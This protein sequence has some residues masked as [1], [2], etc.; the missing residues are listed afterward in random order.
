MGF[1]IFCFRIF[2]KRKLFRVQMPGRCCCMLASLFYLFLAP[3]SA[4]GQE[5]DFEISHIEVR[6]NS[7]LDQGVLLQ[8]IKSKES[9]SGF[10]QFLNKISGDRIGGKPEYFHVEELQNDER[11]LSELYMD[12]GFFH[13]SISSTYVADSLKHSVAITF[14]IDEKKRSFIDSIMFRGMDSLRSDVKEKIVSDPIL[15]VGMPYERTKAAEEIKR[16]LD[17]LTNNGYRYARYVYDSSAAYEYLS[18]N[19]VGLVFYFSPGRQYNFGE[20]NVNVNPPR[21]DITPNLALRQLDFTR[22][23]LYSEQ[24]KVS[25]ERN[26]NRLGIFESAR[27]ETAS[28]RDTVSSSAIPVDVFIKPRIR[29]ELS[30]DFIVSNENSE[31]NLGLGV[32]FTNRN[33]FG[34]G[35][36][37]NTNLQARTQSLGKILGGR[38]FRDPEVVAAVDY[39]L[40]IT[41]PYLFTRSLSGFISSDL[42]IDKEKPYILYIFRNKLGLNK[43][44]ATYTSGSLEWTL[45]RVQPEFL[46][47]DTAS[48]STIIRQE[49]QS[50]FNSILTLS[51]QKDR[52]NDPFSPTE[53]FFN[54]ISIEE[55]GILPKLLQ[56][57]RFEPPYTQYYKITLFGRWYDDLSTN[58]SNI[59]AMKLESGYQDKYGESRQRDVSI[60]LNRR[61]FSGGSSSIR[62]WRAR[63]L[64]AMPDSLVQFGGNFLFEG[65]VELRVNHFR[66]WGKWWF[67]RFDNIWVVYFVDYGN[68][69]SDIG[70]FRLKEIAV[71]TGIGFRY[72]T[73][74]G[75]FRIDYGL[76]GYDPK[77]EAGHQTIFKKQFIAETLGSGVL[78]FGIGH[79]F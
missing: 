31:L 13:T 10:S 72:E 53:G 51:L 76:R 54:N 27:I 16:I 44:F 20:I 52:T 45:E 19:N 69:W 60:P 5:T 30:P 2:L 38:S 46:T 11:L 40:Q 25:S 48:V 34:D 62:G 68:N 28:D 58:R 35:R 3:F 7:F 39:Q 6:G 15:K 37:F 33:F 56:G 57:S 23:D 9:S 55:S 18:T 65:S 78:H 50:Q 22:G 41:Q 26:L 17:I 43:Q 77:A 1:L 29:N 36:T 24:K 71:A 61:F 21:D 49:D 79:A 67:I 4:S 64:G 75:P 42:G 47:A 32:G 14:T 73:F 8:T 63:E 70:D 59:L 74:F 12:H 66:D